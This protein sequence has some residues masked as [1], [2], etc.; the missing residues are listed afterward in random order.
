[1]ERP[2]AG[3]RPPAGRRQV[4]WA[5]RAAPA[6]SRLGSGSERG[7]SRDGPARGCG[8]ARGRRSPG[9]GA[10]R[11][12]GRARRAAIGGASSPSAMAPGA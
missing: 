10:G 6:S 2:P 1:M 5:L 9:R 3:A 4:A 11:C 7:P 8:T 12:R